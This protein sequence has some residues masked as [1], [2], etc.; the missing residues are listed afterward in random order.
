MAGIMLHINTREILQ[1]GWQHYHFLS[2]SAARLF[3][4]DLR[5]LDD[6]HLRPLVQYERLAPV[7]AHTPLDGGMILVGV[8]S[9]ELGHL[10]TGTFFPNV[11]GRAGSV[12]PPVSV[13]VGARGRRVGGVELEGLVEE[14]LE[15]RD[16]GDDHA[17]VLLEA[18]DCGRQYFCLSYY[19][20][21]L[22][23]HS[24]RN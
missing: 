17:D 20:R 9:W 8:A 23:T 14:R 5:P 1:S 16:A 6:P 11:A 24:P 12:A 22:L 18:G 3:H 13:D 21:A 10:K 4:R 2:V 7:I 19:R 15:H